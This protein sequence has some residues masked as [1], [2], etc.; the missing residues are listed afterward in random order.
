MILLHY[1]KKLQLEHDV[2]EYL[3]SE[4]ANKD[5]CGSYEYC[6]YCRKKNKNPCAAA[7][8]K[9]IRLNATANE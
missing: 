7:K 8:R 4:K 5:L 2:M 9:F 1:L 3:A 6:C